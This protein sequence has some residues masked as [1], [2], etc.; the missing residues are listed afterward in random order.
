MTIMTDKI[1]LSVLMASPAAA[2]GAWLSE[3]NSYGTLAVTIVT[4]LS[5]IAAGLYHYER[6]RKMRKERQEKE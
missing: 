5:V 3:A 1:A 4:F 6:W 2:A